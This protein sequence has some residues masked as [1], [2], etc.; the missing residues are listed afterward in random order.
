MTHRILIIDDERNIHTTL[1]RGL[2]LEGLKVESAFTG[3]EGLAKSSSWSPDLILLD[4][5]LPDQSGLEVL[6]QL[7]VADNAP[8]VV[9]MSGH[10]TLDSAVQATRKEL[11]TFWKSLSISIGLHSRSPMRSSWMN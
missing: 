10:G 1:G 9:M 8:A 11:S 3:T 7:M 2:E 4:L 5:K 6:D